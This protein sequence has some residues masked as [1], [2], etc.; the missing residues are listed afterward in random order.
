M[1]TLTNFLFRVY[2][3]KRRISK[4]SG[5]NSVQWIIIEMMTFLFHCRHF[6]VQ[7]KR[8][9]SIIAVCR[10]IQNWKHPYT[11]GTLRYY[12]LARKSW[13]DN[14]NWIGKSLF[15]PNS[16]WWNPETQPWDSFLEKKCGL[17]FL[18]GP[19]RFHKSLW[20]IFIYCTSIYKC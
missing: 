7:W 8:G 5:T 1:G 13:M 12:T 17:L 20:G 4:S 2:C 19:D 9:F 18:Y 11:W 3:K 14:L 10:P 16:M 15:N 6:P